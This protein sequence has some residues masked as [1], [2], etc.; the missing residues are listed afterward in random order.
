M[1]FQRT[2]TASFI[3]VGSFSACE[4]AGPDF[5]RHT[6]IR[7]ADSCINIRLMGKYLTG[8]LEPERCPDRAE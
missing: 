4:G 2:R 5:Q 1:I 7:A 3:E 8:L 6:L